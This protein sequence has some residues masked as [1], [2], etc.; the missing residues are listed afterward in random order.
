MLLFVVEFESRHGQTPTCEE[1]IELQGPT[2]VQMYTLGMDEVVDYRETVRPIEQELNLQGVFNNYCPE[3]SQVIFHG[4]EK[5]F[6]N[7]RMKL[8]CAMRTSRTASH[9]RPQGVRDTCVCNPWH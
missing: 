5:N 7:H 8:F 1:V 2:H 3:H 9:W 6:S 4:R